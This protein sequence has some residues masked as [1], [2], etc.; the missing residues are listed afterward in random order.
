MAER[1]LVTGAAGFVGANLVR[2]LLAD[3]S[4]V[5]AVVRPGSDLWRLQQLANDVEVAEVDLRDAAAVD[6]LTARSGAATI[7]HLAAHGAYSWQTDRRAIFDV[8]VGSLVNLVESALRHEVAA[9]VATGSSSEYGFSGCAPSESELPEPNSDYAVAKVSAT[10]LLG[11]IGRTTAMKTRTLRLYSVYGPYEEPRRL[12]PTLIAHALRRTLPPLTNP[13]T[14]RDFVHV[15]DALDA[16]LAPVTE[17]GESGAVYNVGTGVQTSLEELIELVR[18]L[19]DI[20]LR[21]EWGTYDP[22]TWDTDTWVADSRLIRAELGWQPKVELAD[23]IRA[24]AEWMR[25]AGLERY[26]DRP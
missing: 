18:E 8:V 25:E 5:T 7:F 23:G 22:R 11:H 2:R 15:D 21:P 4:D 13:S 10:F 24:T 20:P 26:D 12:M 16:L 9:F 17:T 6:G 19:F 1:I 3:G 14:A